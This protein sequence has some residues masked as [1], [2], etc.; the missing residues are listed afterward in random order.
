M[1]QSCLMFLVRLF[2]SDKL[3]AILYIYYV[4]FS[5]FIKELFFM[6]LSIFKQVIRFRSYHCILLSD[7][8]I[9]LLWFNEFECQGFVIVY[10]YIQRMS[11]TTLWPFYTVWDVSPC[12]MRRKWERLSGR[13]PTSVKK[14]SQF[15]EEIRINAKK[16]YALIYARLYCLIFDINAFYYNLT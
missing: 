10:I 2:F 12:S 11:K 13:I 9:C 15:T 16:R 5:L 14:S 1:Y 4:F 6:E 7:I 8:Y 3:S